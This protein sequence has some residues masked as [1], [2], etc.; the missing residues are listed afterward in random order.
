M[1][2]SK[3]HSRCLILG[4]SWVGDTVMAQALFRLLKAQQPDRTLDVLAPAFLHP[5]LLRMPEISGCLTLPFAHGVTD[6][7]GRYHFG[8]SLQR[9]PYDEA[10]VLTNSW[11]S[12]FILWATRIQKRTGWLGEQRYGLL[13]DWRRLDK[14]RYPNMVDRFLALGLPAN[15]P[16]PPAEPYWPQFTLDEAQQTETLRQLALALPTA[17]L[18]ILCPGAEYGPAKQWPA[19]HFATLARTLQET[20]WIIWLLGS[21]KDNDFA[22]RIETAAPGCVNLAGRTT[23]SQAIDLLALAQQVVTNDSGLMHIAAALKRPL[24]ALYGPT[25]TVFT[26][27]LS[28]ECH[29]LT[30]DL[31]CRPCHKRTCPLKHHACLQNL[32]PEHV[33]SHCSTRV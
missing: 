28:K 13:T 11:K 1:S 15:A 17:P 9:H 2:Q 20:G 18:A 30:L 4:P 33:R 3:Q 29:I 27:P 23:L 16:L 10:I 5:L 6:M 7:L 31:P 26:P 32:L 12:A 24:V 25:D 19:T 14:T 21:S 8:R 22:N